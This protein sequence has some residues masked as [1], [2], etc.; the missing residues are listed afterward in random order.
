MLFETFLAFVSITAARNVRARCADKLGCSTV[1]RVALVLAWALTVAPSC[2][3]GGQTE[4]QRITPIRR[5]PAMAV[6]NNSSE[7]Q[8]TRAVR[9]IFEYEGDRVRLVSEQPVE[10][11][12]TGFDLPQGLAPGYYVDARDG[13]NR[14]LARVPARGAFAG[15]MEV[16]P[17][18]PGEP[19]SR[20]DVAQPKGAFTVVVPAPE[21]TEHVTVLRIA[22]PTDRRAAPGEAAAAPEVVDLVSFPMKSNK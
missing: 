19:I 6:S 17:E 15:S 18:K 3:A 5:G 12:V 4:W 20:I 21:R 1:E 11:A 7:P 2:A 22:P 16:F 8:P 14:T 13:E 10:M 9:L